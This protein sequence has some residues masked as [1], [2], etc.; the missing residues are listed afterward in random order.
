MYTSK[1]AIKLISTRNI[2]FIG[3]SILEASYCGKTQ[4]PEQEVIHQIS[5]LQCYISVIDSL[6][7]I[8]NYT[9]AFVVRSKLVDGMDWQQIS[10]RYEQIW[11]IGE[12]RTVRTF[13]LKFRS[14]ITKIAYIMNQNSTT[15]W[16]AILEAQSYCLLDHE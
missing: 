15:V 2:L 4:T 7:S 13:Q 9:E 6:F 3:I 14:G 11:G 16:D 1:D 12:G 8:L 10:K 5:V